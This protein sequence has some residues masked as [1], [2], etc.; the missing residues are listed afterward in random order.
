MRKQES[1]IQ[2]A[3]YDFRPQ[4]SIFTQL[5]KGELQHKKD[6]VLNL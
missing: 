1:G 4:Y 2:E 6:S 5:T 3:L